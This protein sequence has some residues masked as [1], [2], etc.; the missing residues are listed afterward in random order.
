V[1]VITP[2]NPGEDRQAYCLGPTIIDPWYIRDTNQIQLD[3]EAITNQDW[4]G[5]RDDL[6]FRHGDETLPT[7]PVDLITVPVPSWQEFLAAPHSAPGTLTRGR[8]CTQS[9]PRSAVLSRM[10]FR[11]SLTTLLD[12]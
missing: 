5:P 6:T 10:R 8:P 2:D 7:G 3:T 4:I 9:K 1:H 12:V 11:L